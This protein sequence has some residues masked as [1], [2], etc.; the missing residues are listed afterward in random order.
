LRAAEG[1]DDD[2]ADSERAAEDVRT[3]AERLLAELR[4]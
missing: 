4:R 1:V 3:E 2:G